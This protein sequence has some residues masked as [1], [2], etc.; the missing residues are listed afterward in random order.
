L[1]SRPVVA[2]AIVGAETVEE[3]AA[4]TSAAEVVPQKR[5]RR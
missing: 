5:S 4:N 2:S 3:I 1:L